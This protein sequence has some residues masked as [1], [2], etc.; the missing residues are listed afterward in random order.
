MKKIMLGLMLLLTVNLFAQFPAQKERQMDSL[1]DAFVKNR[2]FTGVVIVADKNKILYK[3]VEGMASR[4]DKIPNT[5]ETNFNIASMGKTFTATMIMQLVGEGKLSL[6]QKLSSIIPGDSIRNADQITIRHF[7]THSSGVGNYMAAPGY[8]ENCH[9]LKTLKDVLPYVRAQEP[10]LA[11]P[12][13]G[14]DYSNS[15]F[16]ILGRVIEAVTGKSYIDNL[17][18]RIYK[19][20]G[21]QHSYLHYPATFKAPAEAVPYLAFTANTYVNGVVD[22]FPAFSDGG[23]QSNAPDLLKFARGLLSGKILSPVLRDTMWAGKIDFNSGGRY[24]FGWMDNKN[25]YGKAVYSHDGGG[26][27]FTSDLKIV[28]ADG[29]VVIVLI[30]NKVNAREFSTSILDIMYKGTWNKPEQYTEARLMEVIEAKG[31]EYLQSHFSEIINGFKLAKAPDARV[32]IKLSDILDMLNHPDQALAVCE[33]GRKA[34]PGEV[35]FYN[36][37]G[38]IYMNH[39]QFTDAETWFRKAL[40]VDPNDGYAKMMLQQLKV[41]ETSH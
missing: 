34:F 12:G 36:V 27:G 20:L 26:K 21:I 23:M 6:D 29:Y 11:A 13:A 18:G 24:S 8:P 2:Q 16:I 17:Q 35:S 4:E 1:L 19:P 22:E 5:L 28:P 9:P 40:T 31:F 39:K 25:D 7:L 30:N 15:G 3:R 41:Q 32:Y 33:M 37:S 14:F 38:Q 10:T